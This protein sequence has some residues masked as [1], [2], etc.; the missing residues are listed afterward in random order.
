M[1]TSKCQLNIVVQ[2]GERVFLLLLIFLFFIL[3][4]NI[5]IFKLL[6]KYVTFYGMPHFTILYFVTSYF[7]C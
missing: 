6:Q 7:H 3:Y 2:K 5:F 4:V 1:T